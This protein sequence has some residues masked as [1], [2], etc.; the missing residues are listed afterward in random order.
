MP[1]PFFNF[2]RSTESFYILPRIPSWPIKPCYRR[3][4]C[5]AL[6]SQ[7]SPTDDQNIPSPP[8]NHLGLDG[9]GPYLVFSDNMNEDTAVPRIILTRRPGL[10]SPLELGYQLVIRTIRF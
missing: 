6:H 10:L 9:F 7:V 8:L 3:A 4:F 2:M 5:D 1:R